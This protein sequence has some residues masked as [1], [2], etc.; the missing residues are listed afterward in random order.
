MSYSTNG[1]HLSGYISSMDDLEDKV[2]GKE[3]ISF[4]IAVKKPYKAREGEADAY[5]P[6]LQAWGARA[7]SI[8][9]YVGVGCKVSVD[10]HIVTSQYE[11]DGR[12]VYVTYVK[13]DDINYDSFKDPKPDA[14]QKEEPEKPAEKPAMSTGELQQAAE[15]L[16]D[17]DLPF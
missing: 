5:F 15:S 9:K 4:N 3:H 6:R 14:Q 7:V 1:V 2:E 10:G 12:T 17:D 11:K 16:T 8:A 13:V